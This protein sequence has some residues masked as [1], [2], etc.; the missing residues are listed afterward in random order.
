MHLLFV[1]LKVFSKSKISGCDRVHEQPNFLLEQLYRL[2]FT[3]ALQED[4]S[5]IS[6]PHK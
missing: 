2:T 4:N 5:R 3:T 6:P 1:S